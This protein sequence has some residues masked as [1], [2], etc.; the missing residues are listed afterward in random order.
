[1]NRR[2]QASGARGVTYEGL[3]CLFFLGLCTWSVQFLNNLSH[4]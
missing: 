2:M 3:L 4:L 1:M